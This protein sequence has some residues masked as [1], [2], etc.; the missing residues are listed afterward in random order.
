MMQFSKPN[1][2]FYFCIPFVL[3]I[4][5]HRQHAEF[6]LPV[7]YNDKECNQYFNALFIELVKKYEFWIV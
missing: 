6:V 4:R 1:L 5:L 3:H 7:W 2:C